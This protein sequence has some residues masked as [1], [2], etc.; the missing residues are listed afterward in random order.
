MNDSLI[1]SVSELYNASIG[2][3]LHKKI[4]TKAELEDIVLKAPIKGDLDIVRTEEGFAVALSNFESAVELSCTKCLKP[5][6][7]EISI[8]NAEREFFT[9]DPERVEDI[10]DVF[11]MDFKTMSIDLTEMLRQE[12]LLHFPHNP[13][14]FDGCKGICEHCGKDRNKQKCKCQPQSPKKEHKPL[15]DLKKLIK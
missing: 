14:C 1:F 5:L 2:K 15:A 3:S 9:H 11:M 4:D 12:I 7:I 10:N 8:E 6:E 13:V